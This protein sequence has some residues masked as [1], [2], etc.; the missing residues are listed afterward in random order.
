MLIVAM[1][2][3]SSDDIAIRY[4]LPVLRMTSYFHTVAPS[5]TTL[6]LEDWQLAV[7]VF[8]RVHQNVALGAKSVIYNLLVWCNGSAVASRFRI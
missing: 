2:R 5:S 4:V 7:P 6:R 3:S 1:A 8:G